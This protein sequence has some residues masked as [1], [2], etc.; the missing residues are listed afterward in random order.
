MLR[1]RNIKSDLPS[2]WVTVMQQLRKYAITADCSHI[3]VMDERVGIYFEFVNASD[4]D[5]DVNFLLSVHPDLITAENE[6]IAPDR[7]TLRQLLAFMCYRAFG[8]VFPLRALPTAESPA[9]VD[10]GSGL[11]SGSLPPETGPHNS[12]ETQKNAT[13]RQQPGRS[14]KTTRV[15]QTDATEAP[16]TA[17]VADG[18]I[19]LRLRTADTVPA[20]IPPAT[21]PTSPARA[22]SRPDSGF[23]EPVSPPNRKHDAPPRPFSPPGGSS[24]TFTITRVFTRAAAVVTTTTGKSYIAK[25]FSPLHTRIAHSLLQNEVAAYAAAKPLQGRDVPHFYG[26]WEI[27]GVTHLSVLLVEYIAPGTTIA[28]LKR[29]GE[30]ERVRGLQGSAEKAVEALHARGV[31]HGDLVARNLIVAGCEGKGQRVVVVDF[32]C[33]KVEGQEGMRRHWADWVFLKEAFELSEVEGE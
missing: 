22:I 32:D 15:L 9:T 17:W 28:A 3:L 27:P 23:H 4:D 6:F 13:T 2:G 20:L 1:N 24:A 18:R 12:K 29:A 19:T 7:F 10:V 5:E 33:A 25:L 11:Y 31:R 30:Y 16:F 26:T 21:L 8:T 14:A